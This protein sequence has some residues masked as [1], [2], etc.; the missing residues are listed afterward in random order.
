MAQE[1]PLSIAA[2]VIGILTFA[3][4][5]LLG[6]YARAIQLS[7]SVE[8]LN[9]LDDEIGEIALTA[10]RS[11]S[12]TWEFQ[13]QVADITRLE[14][15]WESVMTRMFYLDLKTLVHAFS[16]LKKSTLLRCRSGMSED[17]V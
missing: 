12:E 13:E 16:I 1:S 6:L 2:S 5:I 3:V 7:Q 10:A 8:Q 14:S 9:K 4:A 11:L 15:R 17:L